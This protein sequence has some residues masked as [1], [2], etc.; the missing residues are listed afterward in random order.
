M[1]N[2]WNR[3]PKQIHIKENQFY[4]LIEKKLQ[5]QTKRRKAKKSHNSYCDSLFSS[6]SLY[7]HFCDRSLIPIQAS[8]KA[9][10]MPF[11]TSRLHLKLQFSY[12]FISIS[13][14][15]YC[16]RACNS[17]RLGSRYQSKIED[18]RRFSS[19]FNEI[20]VREKERDIHSQTNAFSIGI[21][22]YW[23]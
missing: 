3:L 15:Y 9:L 10:R 5:S 7:V 19:L 23:R 6:L 17:L 2:L 11:I 18:G 22:I 13:K 8:L 1:C 14:N 20:D 16:S 12:I 21:E 4:S